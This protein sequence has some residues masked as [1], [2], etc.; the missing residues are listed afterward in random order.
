MLKLHLFKNMK[1]I[2]CKKIKYQP[3]KKNKISK[4][5]DIINFILEVFILIIYKK[6]KIFHFCQSN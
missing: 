5:S 6:V 2:Y 4:M 1:E 3:L